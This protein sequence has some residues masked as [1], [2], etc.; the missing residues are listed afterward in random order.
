MGANIGHDGGHYAVSR[1]P[2]IN[3]V[4][5]WGISFICNPIIWQHQHTYAHHSYTNEH[6]HDPDLHHF[7]LLL[8]YTRA[9]TVMMPWYK[10]QVHALYVFFALTFTCFGTCYRNTL[11][12]VF[13]RTLH[14]AVDW[15]DRERLFRTVGLLLHLIVY[16]TIIFIV[17][18]FV[19]RSSWVALLAGII[20]IATAGFYFGCMTQVGHITEHALDRDPIQAIEKRHTI[21]KHSWAAEQI[22]TTNDFCPQSTFMYLLS[23]ALCLQIEHH[24]F[25]SL[26]HCHLQLIQPTVE[27]TCREYN[28]DYKKYASWSAVMDD[29]IK[30]IGS[31]IESPDDGKIK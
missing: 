11:R 20:H 15:T 3:D 8:K 22:E 30:Y 14:G 5:V 7:Y 25:P 10:Q 24:L 16:V 12:V 6:D 1:I 29:T 21:A 2:F 23:G 26:N 19:H 31:V 28:V 9:D 27:Q 4:A 13:E 17:P 18:F